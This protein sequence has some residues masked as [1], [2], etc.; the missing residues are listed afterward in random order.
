MSDGLDK[1]EHL[2]E[3]FCPDENYNALCI[4]MELR[5][6]EQ[7]A[8]MDAAR[9]LRL[10]IGQNAPPIKGWADVYVDEALDVVEGKP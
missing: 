7:R 3:C 8:R 5:E 2:P 10:W 4:C 9:D 6:A 1:P